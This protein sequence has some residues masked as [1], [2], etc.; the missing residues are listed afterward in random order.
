MDEFGSPDDVWNVVRD[1]ARAACLVL[2]CS[3]NWREVNLELITTER[4]STHGPYHHKKLL[5]LGKELR[6]TF[7]VALNQ[8]EDGWIVAECAALLGCVS[9]G[10]DEKKALANI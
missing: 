7:R 9:Q 1:R 10:R 5:R 2:V 6:M 8:A 4:P 3:L